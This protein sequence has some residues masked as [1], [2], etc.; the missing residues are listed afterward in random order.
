LAR[1][2]FAH[3]FFGEA[4]KSKAR[5]RQTPCKRAE[6]LSSIPHRFFCFLFFG[7][8]KKSKACGRQQTGQQTET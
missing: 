7:E 3:L 4:K 2:S 1:L 6:T 5:G 8:A